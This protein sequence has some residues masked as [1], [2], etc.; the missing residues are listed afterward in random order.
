MEQGKEDR[1]RARRRVQGVWQRRYGAE[2]PRG[3]MWFSAVSLV[4]AVAAALLI[5]GLVYGTYTALG[6]TAGSTPIG[7]ARVITGRGTEQGSGTGA[8]GTAGQAAAGS[9]LG[10]KRIHIVALGDSLAYGFGDAS[11]R[12]FAGDVAEWYRQ[13]GKI[14]I[15][16]NLGIGGLTSGGLLAELGQ[17]AVQRTVRS[18][19]LILLSI[20]GNDLNDS[21]GLPQI[22]SRRVALAQRSFTSH[23]TSILSDI[24]RWNPLATIVI[25]GLYNPYGDIAV[26]RPHTDAIVQDWNLAEERVAWRFPHTVVAETFD[27]FALH[28][29]AFL[30]LDHF[31]PNRAGYARIA[32]RIWQDLQG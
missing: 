29:G 9:P 23:L 18:A 25:V 7:D 16:S 3:G 21:A 19:D 32:R 10:R 6:G 31:H 30:Y 17:P 14:V 8:A 2:R 24:S 13:S 28:P 5:C 20:G 15:E 11:G 26:A 1:D 12:G 4:S 22:N 27:L